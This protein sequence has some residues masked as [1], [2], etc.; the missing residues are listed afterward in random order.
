LENKYQSTLIPKLRHLFPGC[1]IE[2]FSDLRQGYSDLIIIWYGLAA[3]LEVKAFEGAE[4][5]PNQR[6]YIEEWNRTGQ[7]IFAE[8]IYP[9]NEEEVLRALQ[10]S[11]QSARNACFS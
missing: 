7:F 5:Q 8:F 6:P 1:M 9:E 11:F 10:R 2:K 4:E 3:V